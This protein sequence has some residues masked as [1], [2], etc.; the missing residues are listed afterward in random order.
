MVPLFPELRKELDCLLLQY[1]NVESCEFVIN[2]YRDPNTNL[3][4]QFA[5]IVKMAGMEPIK[6][7]FDN[8]RMSRSNE[9]YATWGA[10]KE[11]Q[12][13][14][15][16]SRVRADHYL[17]MTDE[18]FNDAANWTKEPTKPEPE[19]ESGEQEKAA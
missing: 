8:M 5:R 6:R 10:F 16:S 2:R 18:D 11:S 7:P 4:T 14:G 1:K 17:M 19:K 15:H 13:I 3:G 9:V 12:W